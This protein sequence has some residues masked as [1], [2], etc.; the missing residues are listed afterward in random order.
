[1][2]MGLALAF[3]L[4]APAVGSRAWAEGTAVKRPKNLDVKNVKEH[5]AKHQTYPATKAEL[6]ASCENLVDFSADD[7]KWFASALPDGTYKSAADVE[8][9]IGIK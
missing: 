4:T 7:K 1:M 8:K 3:S 9:A 6:V 2:M 5:L